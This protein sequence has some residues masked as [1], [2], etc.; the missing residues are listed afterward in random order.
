MK[1]SYLSYFGQWSND[2]CSKG[3]ALLRCRN[4]DSP[5][6]EFTDYMPRCTDHFFSCRCPLVVLISES[7]FVLPVSSVRRQIRL[8]LWWI[9]VWSLTDGTSQTFHCFQRKSGALLFGTI[10]ITSALHPKQTPAVRVVEQ[11]DW[12]TLYG[13]S[14]NSLPE[15]SNSVELK[16]ATTKMLFLSV[17]WMKRSRKESLSRAA[18][19]VR[20]LDGDEAKDGLDLSRGETLNLSGEGRWG[21]NWQETVPRAEQ[22][23]V[24]EV[25]EDTKWV[26]V[27]E[28]EDGAED[29]GR[30]MIGC[31]HRW[32]E[33]PTKS[34]TVVWTKLDCL[35]D[36]VPHTHTDVY[37]HNT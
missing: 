15:S 6:L 5:S 22:R 14:C 35:I 2:S 1:I 11:A 28:E 23:L 18:E 10:K 13:T 8:I 25:K 32:R 21:L 19:H 3:L 9:T 33:Q 36:S 7:T 17:I 24:D 20:M 16:V 4:I 29:R 34:S 26:G 27:R 30:K 31:G 37:M 12:K